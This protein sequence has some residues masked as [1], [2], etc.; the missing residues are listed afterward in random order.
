M[1]VTATVHNFV[2]SESRAV[3]PPNLQILR[4]NRK[5]MINQINDIINM[6]NAICKKK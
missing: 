5:G 3:N 1:I 6:H 2:G 4:I